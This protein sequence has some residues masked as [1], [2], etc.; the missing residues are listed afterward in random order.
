MMIWQ[1]TD[2]WEFWVFTVGMGTNDTYQLIQSF[3]LYLIVQ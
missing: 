3:E 2:N 1:A